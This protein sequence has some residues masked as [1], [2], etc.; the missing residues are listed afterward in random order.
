[1]SGRPALQMRWEGLYGLRKGHRWVSRQPAPRGVGTEPRAAALTKTQ[2]LGRKDQRKAS[3]W[4][5]DHQELPFS[6]IPHPPLKTG[7]LPNCPLP[8]RLH[9]S[10]HPQHPSL[11][12]PNRLPQQTP[13]RSHRCRALLQTCP[14]P[15][16]T[17]SSDTLF[18]A[19][20]VLPTFSFS[21]L[22]TLLTFRDLRANLDTASVVP[23][24]APR[25]RYRAGRQAGGW[26]CPQWQTVSLTSVSLDK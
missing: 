23:V 9:L 17:Q 10:P 16:P 24:T 22:F 8:S 13:S 20:K 7:P 21:Y 4:G 26:N 15:N 1:M 11:P 12:R 19:D 2:S 5:G 25:S 18:R 6:P 14:H 3:P